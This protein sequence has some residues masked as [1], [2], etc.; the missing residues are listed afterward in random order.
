IP[1]AAHH[2]ET[3]EFPVEICKKAW[4]AGLMNNH[5]PEAYGGL[6]LGTFEGVLISEECGYGCSGITTAM[7]ANNLAEAPL[8]VA[9]SDSVKKRFLAPMTEEFQM[10]SYAVTEP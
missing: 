8:I 6:G 9:A 5:I 1:N 3:G 7:E 4:A 10:A 2:D